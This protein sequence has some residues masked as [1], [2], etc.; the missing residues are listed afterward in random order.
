MAKNKVKT[1]VINIKIDAALKSRAAQLAEQLGMPLSLVVQGGLRQFVTKQGIS[2]FSYQPEAEIR[3][4]FKNN[5]G[6]LNPSPYLRLAIKEAR[7]ERAKG[8]SYS[9]SSAAEAIKFLD[10]A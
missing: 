9:F 8:N 5:R 7:Q 1:A 3:G 10:K 4:D 6:A 2:F